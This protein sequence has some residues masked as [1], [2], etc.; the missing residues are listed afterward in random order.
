[1]EGERTTEK[2]RNNTVRER[3]IK[4]VRDQESEREGIGKGEEEVG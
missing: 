2:E 1:M 4:K 3:E